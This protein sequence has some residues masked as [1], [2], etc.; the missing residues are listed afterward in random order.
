M[1]TKED[2]DKSSYSCGSRNPFRGLMY[3]LCGSH[4]GGNSPGG[5]TACVFSFPALEVRN[6]EDREFKKGDLSPD[7]GALFKTPEAF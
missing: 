3:P 2:S 1:T 7:R 4:N 6:T 5:G